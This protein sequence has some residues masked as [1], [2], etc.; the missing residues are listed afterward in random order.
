MCSVEFDRCPS[1]KR[2]AVVAELILGIDAGETR[3]C[4]GAGLRLRQAGSWLKFTEKRRCSQPLT[5]P[6]SRVVRGPSKL[7]RVQILPGFG[8]SELQHCF[9][10][11]DT[12][13]AARLRLKKIGS[14][15]GQ[16]RTGIKTGRNTQGYDF[17]ASKARRPHQLS[18][19]RLTLA[20]DPCNNRGIQ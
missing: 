15:D 20:L 6:R 13:R 17:A 5:N 2:M 3:V 10:S 7:T 19:E 8:K 16:F 12:P 14:K 4:V 11:R 18:A 1:R 9:G